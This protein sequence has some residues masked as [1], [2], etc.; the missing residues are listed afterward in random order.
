MKYCFTSLRAVW[1]HIV[2]AFSVL[3][4]QKMC[5]MCPVAIL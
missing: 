5:K 4:I 2:E 1:L 3:Q